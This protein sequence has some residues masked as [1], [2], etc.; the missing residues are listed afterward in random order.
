M[1]Q[2]CGERI[3]DARWWEM[4]I[5]SLS[6]SLASEIFL[7]NIESL[8]LCIQY[9]G[10]L[11][12]HSFIRRNAGNEMAWHASH[13]I[14]GSLTHT[15][16]PKKNF[17]ISQFPNPP[18]GMFSRGK[19]KNWRISKD[20]TRNPG[21]L[22]AAVNQGFYLPFLHL[23]LLRLTRWMAISGFQVWFVSLFL[24]LIYSGA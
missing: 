24:F 8:H 10:T 5:S 9:V 23:R 22:E 3:L 4:V 21:T 19:R 14:T 17:P 13:L 16:T 1:S 7:G 11:F 20:Q 6:E 2:R 15:F 12:T 18:P